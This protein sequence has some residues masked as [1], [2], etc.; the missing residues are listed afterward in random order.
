MSLHNTTKQNL[1]QCLVLSRLDYSN[2]LLHGACKS[3]LMKLQRVQNAAARLINTCS[4]KCHITPYLYDLHWLPVSARIQYKII[5]LVFKCLHDMAPGY[6]KDLVSVRCPARN[7]RSSSHLRLEVPAFRTE[8]YGRKR[9]DVAAALLWNKL[10]LNVKS[11]D[12]LTIFKKHLKIHLFM[13]AFYWT[14]IFLVNFSF[15]LSL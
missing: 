15:I 7:L 10:P 1:V 12:T 2:A 13:K 5:L 8:S 14:V 4:Y 3:D 6:L 9:F 11:C